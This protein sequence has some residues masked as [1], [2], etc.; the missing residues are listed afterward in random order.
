MS[1]VTPLML[2]IQNRDTEAAKAALERDASQATTAL[3]GGISALLFA[4]YNGT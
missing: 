4:L 3:P 1:N 2:A